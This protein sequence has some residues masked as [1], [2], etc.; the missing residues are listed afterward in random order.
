[1]DAEAQVRGGHSPASRCLL[2]I[3]NSSAWGECGQQGKLVVWWLSNQQGIHAINLRRQ[4]RRLYM[5]LLIEVY[6]LH[7]Y[8]LCMLD[9]SASSV[10]ILALL[11]L[12]ACRVLCTCTTYLSVVGA[13]RTN[14]TCVPSS[15]VCA[16]VLQ[17]CRQ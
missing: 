13:P 17:A 11:V 9:A 1:V 5:V 10:Y 12:H 15:H 8:I 6:D 4:Q 2:A 16:A 3:S 14:A 7:C